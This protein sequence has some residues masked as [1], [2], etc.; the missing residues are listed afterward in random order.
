MNPPATS[1]DGEEHSPRVLSEILD[2]A[3]LGQLC[4]LMK[5]RQS[6]ALFKDMFRDVREFEDKVKDILPV[7]NDSAHFRRVPERELMRCKL[8]CE[9]LI[10]IISKKRQ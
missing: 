2:F 9:D 4:E 1:L 8:S 7:R 6:W 3:Y 5:S 10:A